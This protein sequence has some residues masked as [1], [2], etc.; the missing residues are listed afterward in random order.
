MGFIAAALIATVVVAEVVSFWDEIITGLQ[1]IVETVKT[2]IRGLFAGVKAFVEKVAGALRE[3][4][5]SYSYVKSENQ[6]YMEQRSI[7]IQ[8]TDVPEEIKSRLYNNNMVDIT[9]QLELE[10]E[11]R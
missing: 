5:K 9:D 10:M 6:W 3:V 8:S 2:V 7:P 1:R 4:T 11:S